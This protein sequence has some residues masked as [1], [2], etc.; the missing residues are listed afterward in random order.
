MHCSH[1]QMNGGNTIALKSI[2]SLQSTEHLATLMKAQSFTT[3]KACIHCYILW[4][5]RHWVSD[6]RYFLYV[7]LQC[8]IKWLLDIMSWQTSAAMHVSWTKS[9][10]RKGIVYSNSVPINPQVYHFSL[11]VI[12]CLKKIYFK[13]YFTNPPNHRYARIQ[14]V[15]WLPSMSSLWDTTALEEFYYLWLQSFF[16]FRA[17]GVFII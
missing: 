2:Q 8:H 16:T 6:R 7:P 14:G 1:S 17:F 9:S 10:C 15:C 11:G 5:R 12:P 13:W 3:E 4:Q